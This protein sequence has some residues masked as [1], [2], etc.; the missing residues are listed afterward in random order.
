VSA[1]EEYFLGVEKSVSG[2]AW[3]ERPMAHRTALAISQRHGLPELLGRVLA[4]RNVEIDD[5]EGF[6]NPT[7]RALMPAAA[8]IRDLDRG[9]ERLADAILGGEHIGVI[10]DYDVDGTCSAAAMHRF[11]TSLGGKLTVHI[12]NRLDEGYGPN[13][14]TLQRFH[15]A[16][17]SL[18]VTVDCGIAAH[19]PLGGARDLGMDVIVVDH[20]QASETLP[21]AHAVINPNRLDDVSGQGQLAAAGVTFVL[22]ASVR[23]TLRE[24]G[25]GETGLDLLELLDLVAL[26]TVCDVVPLTGLNRALVCQGLKVMA[27]RRNVGITALGDAAGLKRRPD[28]HALG[29]VLGPRIN[30]AGRLGHADLAFELLVTEDRSRAAR[31]ALE[32]ETLNRQRQTI[33]ART[34]DLAFAQ[35]EAALGEGA[36]LPVLIVSGERW[37]PGV[38]GLVAGRL[39]ERFHVPAI[40]LGFD[41][42]G[43]GQ[44][45]GRS[46]AGVDLGSA[47]RD[48]LEAGLLVKG[49]G[50]AMAAGLTIDKTRLGDFRAFMEERLRAQS[51]AVMARGPSLSIDGALS[52]RG[53]NFELIELL[54]HAGPYGI[55]NPHPRFVLPAHKVA[56]GDLAG[57]E[58]VRCA[59]VAPDGARISGIAFRALGAPLG[60]LLLSERDRPLHLAGRLNVNDWNG[61]RTVQL[62]IDDAVLAQ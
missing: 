25:H 60:E 32:L 35:G 24:R 18:V 52:A 33:E 30:A 14:A 34:F 45:S 51:G 54:E 20:H 39:K 49:G 37:H 46:V 47:V 12:P 8:G 23:K 3:R 19:E 29:F 13:A 42:D 7:L 6:L 53:A 61:S 40:A 15:E 1:P 50:H 36:A 5:A 21:A 22:L 38:L 10:G 4:A 57:R 16:G 41:A 26:A 31:I 62:M 56:Y 17:V 55:G 58:H 48:A 11:V 27:R 44:G 28:T 59:L 43:K 2:R 9:A